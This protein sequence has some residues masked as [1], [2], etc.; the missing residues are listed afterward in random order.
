MMFGSAPFST[1]SYQ[2]DFTGLRGIVFVGTSTI[3]K[4]SK[5]VQAYRIQLWIGLDP[6]P[7]L[8][9]LQASTNY[10]SSEV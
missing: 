8:Q 4:D 1:K 6:R 3:H 9:F 5:I 10:V 7:A 2:K